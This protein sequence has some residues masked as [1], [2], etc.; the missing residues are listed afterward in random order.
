MIG[1]FR[2]FTVVSVLVILGCLL[3]S[4]AGVAYARDGVSANLAPAA[5]MPDAREL[6]A[7]GAAA[8][9]ASLSGWSRW[10]GETA[11]RVIR[12]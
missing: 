8:A 10:F 6:G 9:A 1:K 7:P 3:N 2:L 4:L 12:P 11:W 5:G